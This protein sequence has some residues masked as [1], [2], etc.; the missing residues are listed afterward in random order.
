MFTVVLRVPT[1]DGLNSIVKVS[2]PPAAMEV[3]GW[4][5]MVKSPD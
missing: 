2:E 5:V 4:S 3:A 1:A